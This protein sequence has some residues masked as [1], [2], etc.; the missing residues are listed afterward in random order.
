MFLEIFSKETNAST[1][2][3]KREIVLFQNSEIFKTESVQKFVIHI[4][5]VSQH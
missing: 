1:K 3:K 5:F 2:F 4:V